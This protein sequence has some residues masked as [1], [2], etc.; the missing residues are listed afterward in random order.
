[1]RYWHTSNALWISLLGGCW[2]CFCL[3]A[4]CFVNVI[5]STTYSDLHQ[6]RNTYWKIV[7]SIIVVFL[8]QLS[9]SLLCTILQ[10]RGL[11]SNPPKVKIYP[12]NTVI[13]VDF[14]TLNVSVFS[15]KPGRNPRKKSGFWFFP[16]EPLTVWDSYLQDCVSC[17]AVIRVL[18]EK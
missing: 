10:I 3:Q 9:S 2:K 12:K 6:V 15:E 8:W 4:Y 16:F 11:P 18:V 5:F 13:L 14:G 17:H 1:M 7:I